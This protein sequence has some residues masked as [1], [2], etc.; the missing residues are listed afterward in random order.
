MDTATLTKSCCFK[1]K[2]HIRTVDVSKGTNVLQVNSVIT[3]MPILHLY[4]LPIKEYRIYTLMNGTV[5]NFIDIIHCLKL[6]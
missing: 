3:S 6:T 4:V 1:I 5:N 2:V